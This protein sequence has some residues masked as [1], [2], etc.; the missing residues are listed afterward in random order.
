M[1]RISRLAQATSIMVALVLGAV[2]ILTSSALSK[3]LMC[4]GSRIGLVCLDEAGFR[5][6]DKKSGPLVRE[7]VGASTATCGN[8]IYFGN[9][10]MVLAFD[11]AG[12]EKILTIPQSLSVS[13]FGISIMEISCR[14]D[15][16][17]WVSW[18][19]GITRWDGA[20]ASHWLARDIQA[21]RGIIGIYAVA[22]GPNGSTWIGTGD[23]ATYFFSDGAWKRFAD[24]NGRMVVDADGSLWMAQSTGLKVFRGGSWSRIAHGLPARN[25][26]RDMTQDKAGD[27]WM[28]TRTTVLRYAGGKWDEVALPV[29]ANINSLYSDGAGALYVT[30]DTGMGRFSGGTWEWR[31]TANSTLPG[32]EL[33]NMAVLG[34]AP[35]LPPAVAMTTGTLSGRLL[36]HDR[37]PIADAEIQ[38]CLSISLSTDGVESP[39]DGKQQK[40]A[41]VTNAEGRFVFENV[42]AGEYSMAVKPDRRGDRW[43]VAGYQEIV[44]TAGKA[45]DAGDVTLHRA[46]WDTRHGRPPKAT[47]PR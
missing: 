33:F 37:A 26:I 45:N 13:P 43:F 21:K 36:W 28:D 35:A 38:V 6:H 46:K 30:S 23:G 18:Q 11:G 3:D 7:H 8:R 29:P 32:N 44:A 9:G 15:G 19:E 25:A 10:D 22:A 2:P 14:K 24:D 5:L 34:K 1:S 41:A 12:F 16:P 20:K 40:A 39:C 17:L 47:P 4:I 27:L 31:N 42:S